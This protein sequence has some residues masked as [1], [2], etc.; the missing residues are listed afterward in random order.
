MRT[1]Q[2]T[3]VYMEVI[4]PVTKAKFEIWDLR[5]GDSWADFY[6]LCE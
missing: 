5:L 1:L 2:N 3:R 6:Y 4:I